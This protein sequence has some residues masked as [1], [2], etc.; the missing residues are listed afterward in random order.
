[1]YHK[2]RDSLINM[3]YSYRGKK[4]P[5]VPVHRCIVAGLVQTWNNIKTLSFAQ[6]KK[7]EKKEN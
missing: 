4:Y 5:N 1:M 6:Y 3:R 2:Y 7:K